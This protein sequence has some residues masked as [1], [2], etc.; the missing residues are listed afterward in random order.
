MTRTCSQHQRLSE[1]R[2]SFLSF[3]MCRLSLC[4]MHCS[5]VSATDMCCIAQSAKTRLLVATLRERLP[6]GCMVARP[7]RGRRVLA[8]QCTDAQAHR[9]ALHTHAR[10]HRSHARTQFLGGGGLSGTAGR[11]NSSTPACRY[12]QYG[13]ART[14]KVASFSL[15]ACRQATTVRSKRSRAH[16]SGCVQLCACVC[17]RVSPPLPPRSL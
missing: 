4:A 5:T 15:H 17:A 7:P 13:A 14:R 2:K 8:V 1:R 16:L 12:S 9:E 11:V 3:S 6:H 10:I